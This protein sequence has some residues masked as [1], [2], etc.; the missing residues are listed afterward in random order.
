MKVYRV[1]LSVHVEAESKDAAE[2]EVRKLSPFEVDEIEWIQ[3]L[4]QLP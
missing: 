4:P 3:E 1:T 2:M